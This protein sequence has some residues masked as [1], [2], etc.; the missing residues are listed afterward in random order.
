MN[1]LIKERECI[2]SEMEIEM[3]EAKRERDKIRR[4]YK[5]RNKQREKRFVCVD[6]RRSCT[7]KNMTLHVCA[8]D[9]SYYYD[10]DN[11]FI[12]RSK[13]QYYYNYFAYHFNRHY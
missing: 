1:E 8:T 2:G 3:K 6:K 12:F 10:Y 11:R 5:F 7:R 4:E 13:H 9:Y